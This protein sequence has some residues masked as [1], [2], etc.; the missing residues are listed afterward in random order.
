MLYCQSARQDVLAENPTFNA[1]DI[2]RKI[3]EKWNKLSDKEKQPFMKKAAKEKTRYDKEMSVY[4]NNLGSNKRK[5]DEG[6]DAPPTK[7]KTEKKK[8]KKTSEGK[9]KQLDF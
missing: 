5:A 2:A 9:K 8:S 6:S 7:R 4:R 1:V 3:G